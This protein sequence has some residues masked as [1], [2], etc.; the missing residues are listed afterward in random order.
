MKLSMMLPAKADRRWTLASQMGV[1]HVISKLAPELTGNPPPYEEQ[2]LKVAQDEYARAGFELTGLEG[3]QF[4]MSRIKL[5]LRGRDEDI[6]RYQQ[7]LKVMGRCGVHLLC[8][9]FMAR[10]GWYRSASAIQGRGGAQVSGF[11]VQDADREGL[12]ELGVIPSDRIWD[13]YRYFIEAVMP[14][15]EEAGVR[16]ALHPD[17]PPVP[18]LRGIGRIFHDRAGLDRALSLSDS[19]SHALTFCQATLTAM[20]ENLEECINTWRERIAFIHV[21]DLRG[22]SEDFVE[23]FPEDGD[24]DMP[25]VFRAYAKAGLNVPMRPDHAPA[26]EGDQVHNGPVAGMNVGY[27]AYGMVYTVGYIKGLLQG[28]DLQFT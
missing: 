24:T 27:E 3:D 2:S 13:N 9:N 4:D 1:R 10:I 6:E 5:G 12:T 16:M 8:Y 21:R 19:P 7:M 14:A 25:A 20:G 18:S 17:D 22:T 26:I 15:A 23:T 28:S 11:K